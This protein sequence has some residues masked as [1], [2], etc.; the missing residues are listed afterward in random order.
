MKYTCNDI[1]N[2]QQTIAIK[3]LFIYTAKFKGNLIENY[4]HRI[5]FFYQYLVAQADDVS[6]LDN[7]ECSICRLCVALLFGFWA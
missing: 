3:L 7:E 1:A 5:L 4:S 2:N 6:S